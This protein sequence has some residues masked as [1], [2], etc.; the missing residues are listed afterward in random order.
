MARRK[1]P[2]L[3]RRHRLRVERRLRHTSPGGDRYT[4]YCAAAGPLTRDACRPRWAPPSSRRSR[5]RL[6]WDELPATA[7]GEGCPWIA[8]A[9]RIVQRP[10][11]PA[12]QV[13]EL[14]ILEKSFPPRPIELP[15]VKRIAR[16]RRRRRRP[17]RNARGYPSRSSSTTA[18][19]CANP[20]PPGGGEIAP[21]YRVSPVASRAP[22]EPAGPTRAGGRDSPS[23]HS[24]ELPQ[25]ARAAGTELERTSRTKRERSRPDDPSN[26]DRLGRS[27]RCAFRS[28]RIRQTTL[29][30][31][32]AP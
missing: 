27:S 9:N 7:S 23:C 14:V 20:S 10:P 28:A 29:P 19:C 2:I 22:R 31:A 21:H 26:R 12:R 17:E 11:T 8:H 6:E 15:A 30:R 16:R 24:P 18:A 3:R 5:S 13:L 1:R 32:A 4:L 25:R